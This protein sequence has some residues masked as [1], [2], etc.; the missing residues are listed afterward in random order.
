MNKKVL[1]A[2]IAVMISAGMF[3][4]CGKST[5]SGGEIN[6]PQSDK[7]A[8]S[9]KQ[10]EQPKTFEAVDP[11]KTMINKAV[12]VG[13][14]EYNVEYSRV[15]KTGK[16]F[17]PKESGNH[18]VLIG[19]SVKN[20]NSETLESRYGGLLATGLFSLKDKDHKPQFGYDLA[21]GTGDATGGFDSLK[22]IE[23]GDTVT[24]EIQYEVPAK[25]TSFLLELSEVKDGIAP[26]EVEIPVAQK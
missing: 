15:L 11:T 13:N 18:F 8:V 21:C 4:G 7:P 1:C 20:T 16:N 3:V 5:N 25:N 17:A 2:V 23:A 14:I 22:E 19:V 10:P 6:K 12:K 9:D 24:G 26:V